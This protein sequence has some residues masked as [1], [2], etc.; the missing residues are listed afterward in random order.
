MSIE[1]RVGPD[2]KIDVGNAD[3]S[4]CDADVIWIDALNPDEAELAELEKLA[5]IEVPNSRDMSEIELS[6]RLYRE[7]GALVMIASFIPKS[8]TRAMPPRPA[9]F[10]LK[11]N[12]LLTVRF[13]EFLSFGRVAADIARNKEKHTTLSI[14]CRLLEEAV[15]DRADS[16]EYFMRSLET[17]TSQMFS[18]LPSSSASPD[19]DNPGLEH[20]LRAIGAMGE[21]VSNLQ[22]SITSLQRLVNFAKVYIP[23]KRLGANAGVLNSLR[24]DLT[25][26]SDEAAF[27]MNKL[28]FNLDATLGLINLE[29]TKVIRVLSIITLVLSPPVLIAGIYGMN[30]HIMPEL[31]WGWGYAWSL[32]LMAVSAIASIWYLKRKRW[33]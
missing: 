26:L 15:S 27:F 33:F 2:G 18:P 14:F 19:L 13:C 12:L 6:N 32:G 16:I 20:I 28:S 11:E 9:T 29:E 30:F 10:I 1:Y 17:L 21:R 5:G 22:E 4:S 23:E 8:D 3:L 7:D 24:N 31:E 25:A